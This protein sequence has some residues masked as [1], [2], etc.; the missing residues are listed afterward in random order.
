MVPSISIMETVQLNIFS[1]NVLPESAKRYFYDH[2]PEAKQMVY[3][4]VAVI[5]WL[6]CKECICRTT[7]LR[8]ELRII[9]Y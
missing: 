6:Y 7:G 1:Q 8:Y 3:H 4:W 5:K 9:I 2:I